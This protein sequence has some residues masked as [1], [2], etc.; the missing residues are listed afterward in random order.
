MHLYKWVLIDNGNN[1]VMTV[2]NVNNEAICLCLD[3]KFLNNHLLSH[4][5]LP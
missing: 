3:L 5:A 2:Q 1:L 4:F